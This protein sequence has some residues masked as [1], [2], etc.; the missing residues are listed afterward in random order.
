MC[1]RD[2]IVFLRFEISWFLAGSRCFG[3]M[4]T[5]ELV[6]KG[7]EWTIIER[8]GVWDG[9]LNSDIAAGENEGLRCCDV[10]P[11]TPNHMAS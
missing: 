11:A 4:E 3:P 1:C 8:D 9:V 5:R 7:M 6:D 10:I 2:E